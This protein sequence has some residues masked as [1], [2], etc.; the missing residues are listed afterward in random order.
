MTRM[1][2]IKSI[3]VTI[4]ACLALER[5]FA[6]TGSPSSK[7]HA[8]DLKIYGCHGL[9]K[10]HTCPLRLPDYKDAEFNFPHISLINSGQ[11]LNEEDFHS[12]VQILEK[13]SSGSPWAP[14]LISKTH[15]P[16]PVKNH[17][18]MYEASLNNDPTIN[19]L[20]R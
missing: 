16:T 15:G 1:N 19:K 8:V 18:T 12:Y 3:F 6:V 9:G 5:A 10:D 14:S 4:L 11:S 13:F 20:A 17:A 7:N 2:V